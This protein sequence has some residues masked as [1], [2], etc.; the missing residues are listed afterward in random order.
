MIKSII[1]VLI[2]LCYDFF[3]QQ[4][5]AEKRSSSCGCFFRE[6]PGGVRQQN[7]SGELALE[8]QAEGSRFG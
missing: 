4:V 3:R 6:L 8:L 2:Y 1:P 5:N 7:G